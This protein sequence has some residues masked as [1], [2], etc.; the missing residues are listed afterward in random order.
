VPPSPGHKLKIAITSCKRHCVK[1]I[2]D[3]K[4][5]DQLRDKTSK[6]V[7]SFPP[8]ESLS[9]RMKG[10]VISTRLFP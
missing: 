2:Q 9:E 3:R 5:I 6:P 8:L 1:S 7:R 10:P 4:L